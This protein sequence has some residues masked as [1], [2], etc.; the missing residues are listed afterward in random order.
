MWWFVD[1]ILIL[2]AL[3]SILGMVRQ[4]SKHDSAAWTNQPAAFFLLYDCPFIAYVCF[5][6]AKY[7]TSQIRYW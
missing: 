7:K 5:F 3:P 1:Y 2:S 6:Y 4:G